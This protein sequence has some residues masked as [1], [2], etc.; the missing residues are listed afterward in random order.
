MSDAVEARRKTVPCSLR[1]SCG[2]CFRRSGGIVPRT[3]A[4]VAIATV[5]DGGKSYECAIPLWCQSATQISRVEPMS[6]LVMVTPTHTSHCAHAVQVF[7][8]HTDRAAQEYIRRHG[9][10]GLQHGFSTANLLKFAL[11]SLTRY[12]LLLYVD[13]DIDLAHPHAVTA[14]TWEAS[15]A[16]LLQTSA[17]FV[18]LFDHASPVNGG[19]WL[20]RPRCHLCAPSPRPAC[21]SHRF[22][23]AAPDPPSSSTPADSTMRSVC[24]A[25]AAGRHS[26]AS[27]ALAR[28]AKSVQTAL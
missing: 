5:W 1:P 22:L 16:A 13:L 10:R 14:A 8:R 28:R 7:P 11:F 21:S 18:G 4:R 19:L 20:A 6:E 23:P 12:E 9:S 26:T 27:K 25:M 15:T 3:L 24:C 17:L 2:E